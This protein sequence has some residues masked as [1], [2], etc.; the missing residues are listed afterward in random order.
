MVRSAGKCGHFPDEPDCESCGA[1]CGENA[2][3]LNAYWE[4]SAAQGLIRWHA[5]FSLGHRKIGKI[6][7]PRAYVV[8]GWSFPEGLLRRVRGASILGYFTSFRMTK[9]PWW[10]V[11]VVLAAG[12]G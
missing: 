4:I 2:D 5:E 10:P 11:K 1:E 6:V 9:L 3:D 12:E 7:W 8:G